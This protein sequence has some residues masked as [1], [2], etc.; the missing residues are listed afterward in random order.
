[1]PV[2]S[3]RGTLTLILGMV[4]MPPVHEDMQQGAGKQDQ[5]REESE[6]VCPVLGEQEKARNSEK[7]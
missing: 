2:L 1:M 7:G 5:E 6:E 3:G 4:A